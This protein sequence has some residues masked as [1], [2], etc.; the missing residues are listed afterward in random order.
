MVRGNGG[1]PTARCWFHGGNGP[2]IVD[3]SNGSHRAPATGE[4]FWCG[5]N[6]FFEYHES[7][8]FGDGTTTNRW[9][10]GTLLR[11][12]LADGSAATEAPQHMA[13]SL[14]AAVGERTVIATDNALVAYD[15]RPRPT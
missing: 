1:P 10:G 8:Y 3:L 14:G 4:G 13:R 7:K 15:R 6:R 11:P 5:E 9:R 12:C 2:V